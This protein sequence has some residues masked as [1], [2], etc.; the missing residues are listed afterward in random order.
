MNVFDY[1][2][3]GKVTKQVPYVIVILSCFLWI[4][5]SQGEVHSILG[6]LD[7]F[8]YAYYPI[9]IWFF[10]Q[11]IHWYYSSGFVQIRDKTHD[12]I[13]FKEIRADFITIILFSLFI[14]IMHFLIMFQSDI[15]I[16]EYPMFFVQMCSSYALLISVFHIMFLVKREIKIAFVISYGLFLFLGLSD[17]F[18]FFS[19]MLE[20]EVFYIISTLCFLAVASI[21]EICVMIYIK[22]KRDTYEIYL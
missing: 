14:T 5:T 3:K 12:N 7:Y 4:N 6:Y 2:M 17:V 22:R 11:R 10:I 13:F 21:L 8:V 18:F 16:L 19:M 20:K 9:A 1:V 15:D